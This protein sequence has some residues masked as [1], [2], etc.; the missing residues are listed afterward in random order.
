ME[1]G[2]VVLPKNPV[3]LCFHCGE[4]FSGVE[5]CVR[6]GEPFAPTGGESACDGCLHAA[7]AAE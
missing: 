3:D 1:A 6:C 2:Q 5:K 7:I 4:T